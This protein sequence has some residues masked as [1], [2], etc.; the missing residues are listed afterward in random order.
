MNFCQGKTKFGLPCRNKVGKDAMS[1][2][3]LHTS[4]NSATTTTSKND[5]IN[6]YQGLI[7]PDQINIYQDVIAKYADAI[8]DKN[9]LDLTKEYG[10]EKFPIE[11][12]A[13]IVSAD[14]EKSIDKNLD[15]VNKIKVSDLQDLI[16]FDSV[17]PD[18]QTFKDEIQGCEC[19][20]TNL[21]NDNMW[22]KLYQLWNSVRLLI[23]S[24]GDCRTQNHTDKN[25]S[26]NPPVQVV[27][28]EV[29]RNDDRPITIH[30]IRDDL[31]VGG[32]KQR[33][34]CELM[35]HS[36]DTEFI[37]ASPLNGYAMVAI[38]YCASLFGKK[39]IIFV[40]GS[41][42]SN[43]TKKA[44]DLGAT[45]NF[46]KGTLEETEAEA[47]KYHQKNGGYL[48]PFGMDSDD[49][50]KL[51]Y[52]N[53]KEA[54]K[55]IRPPKRIWI[56]IGSG[57]LSRIIMRLWPK[58][59]IMPVRIGKNIWEDQYTSEDWKRLGGRSTIDRLRVIDDPKL[60]KIRGFQYQRFNDPAPILPPWPS[61]PTYD[62]KVYQRILQFG[63]DG[64]FVW[65]VAP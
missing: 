58:A 39:A 57:T 37:Y 20:D 10:E 8:F 56:P 46:V 61:M 18:L 51:L 26:I 44:R 53:L 12:A 23:V 32:T 14:T 3:Y 33:A 9:L 21:I 28:Y 47:T 64:D 35:A 49:F 42:P 24:N 41:T 63:S 38:S 27:D 15:S 22:N 5:Q 50:N 30:V 52:K 65:N 36:T 6:I 62:A 48:V 45:I 29:I 31:L 59:E 2:C 1:F 13:L 60:P 17:I 7:Y 54:T 34:M 16:T 55:H 40:S 43:S 25:V 19:F 11:F 4:P